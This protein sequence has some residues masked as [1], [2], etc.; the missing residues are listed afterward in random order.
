[1]FNETESNEENG[2]TD[3]FNTDNAKTYR[4]SG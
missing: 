1:M 3:I 4:T 2:Y